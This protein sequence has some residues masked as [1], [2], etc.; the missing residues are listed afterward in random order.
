[1]ISEMLFEDDFVNFS[2]ALFSSSFIRSEMTFC[3]SASFLFFL[4]DFGSLILIFL[5]YDMVS[6]CGGVP[7]YCCPEVRVDLSVRSDCQ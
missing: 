5:V 6:S 4:D 1:M 3:N 2:S 7:G